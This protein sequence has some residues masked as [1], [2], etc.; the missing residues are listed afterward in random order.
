MINTEYFLFIATKCFADIDSFN[1]F[2]KP[3]ERSL[4]IIPFTDKRTERHREVS[5]LAQGL[6][7]GE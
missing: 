6:T 1:P 2:N 4:I 5:T 3:H 7:A